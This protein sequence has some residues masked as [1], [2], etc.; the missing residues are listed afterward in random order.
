MNTIKDQ[1]IQASVVT[2][3][4]LAV[5]TAVAYSPPLLAV[6]AVWAGVT[7]WAIYEARR[8]HARA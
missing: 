6:W 8:K 3:G 5:V 7:V 4:I 1:G 2:A